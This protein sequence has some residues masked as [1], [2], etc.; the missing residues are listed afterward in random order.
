MKYTVS[1]IWKQDT[2]NQ[3]MREFLFEGCEGRIVLGLFTW[4]IDDC[5]LSASSYHPLSLASY[6]HV[7]ILSLLPFPYPISP[8]SSFLSSLSLSHPLC[9]FIFLLH[10]KEAK[11]W[12]YECFLSTFHR[13]CPG[14]TY[15]CSGAYHEGQTNCPK[16]FEDP[17]CSTASAP[18]LQGH[19]QGPD[20]YMGVGEQNSHST[21]TNPLTNE[22]IS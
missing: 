18:G 1:H 16:S 7:H 22:L 19:A 12:H 14:R 5:F 2:Q 6:V 4:L 20:S 3:D 15:H 8:S 17:P 11:G 13:I 9:C 10:M 21:T